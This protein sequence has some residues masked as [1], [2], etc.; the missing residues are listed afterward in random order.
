MKR[1]KKTR[2]EDFFYF[3]IDKQGIVG[4]IF[5]IELFA[6]AGKKAFYIIL[7]TN[8]KFKS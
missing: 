4:T 1:M 2:F 8:R 3:E 7:W 6:D 5:E